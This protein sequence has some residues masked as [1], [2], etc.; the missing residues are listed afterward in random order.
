DGKAGAGAGDPLAALH[1]QRGVLFASGLIA[2]EGLI[3]ILF[4][5]L[6]VTETSIALGD[7]PLLGSWASTAA[8][9]LLAVFMA[10]IVC[11]KGLFRRAAREG[12]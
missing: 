2:G 12:G 8:Y 9:T 3:G 5:L 11:G 7:G 1:L 6:S 4:A 10:R